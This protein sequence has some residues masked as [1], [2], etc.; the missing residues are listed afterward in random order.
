MRYAFLLD[1]PVS[2]HLPAAPGTSPKFAVKATIGK[3][4]FGEFGG[5]REGAR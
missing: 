1:G 4:H 5:G 3:G 2:P